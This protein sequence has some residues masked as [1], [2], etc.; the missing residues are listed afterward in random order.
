M[1]LSRF[2]EIR[3]GTRGVLTW[4]FGCGP[5]LSATPRGRHRVRD[6]L[7]PARARPPVAPDHPPVAAQAPALAAAAAAAPGEARSASTHQLRTA[8]RSRRAANR[9]LPLWTISLQ[10]WARCGSF[11]FASMTAPSVVARPALQLCLTGPSCAFFG[12]VSY[13]H[14]RICSEPHVN[15]LSLLSLTTTLPTL[16]AGAAGC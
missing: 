11:T 13:S 4:S 3:I 6:R 15:L 1:N 7:H 5:R 9:D 16:L 2:C 10:T 14:R 8:Q 12:C